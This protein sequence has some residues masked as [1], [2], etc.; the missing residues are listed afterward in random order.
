MGRL[1]LFG[2]DKALMSAGG[3]GGMG[4][5]TGKLSPD[6]HA[7]FVT[8]DIWKLTVENRA[9]DVRWMHDADGNAT[10]V[11]HN[12]FDDHRRLDTAWSLSAGDAL[13][14]AML[15]DPQGLNGGTRAILGPAGSPRYLEQTVATE[16][17]ARYTFSVHVRRCPPAPANT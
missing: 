2:N 9:S 17:G 6:A 4:S 13:D 8:R 12:L 3:G 16:P 11:A 10:P 15:P 14:P 7:N 1:L 5:L